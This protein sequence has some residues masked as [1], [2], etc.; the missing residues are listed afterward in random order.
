MDLIFL[1]AIV[2]MWV[3]TWAAVEGCRILGGAK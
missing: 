3:V 2:A 1:G